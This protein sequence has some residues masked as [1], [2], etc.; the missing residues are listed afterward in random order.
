MKKKLL[1]IFNVLLIAVIA[2]LTV[3][4]LFKDRELGTIL[5]DLDKA[6]KLWLL[7]GAALAVLFVA[8]E[9]VIIRYLLRLFGTRFSLRRCLKYSFV[10]FFFSFITPS[11][12][13][14]QP[15]QLYYMRKD[16]AS[17]GH[18]SIILLLVTITYKAVLVVFGAVFLIFGHS[19]IVSCV[20]DWM[21]LLIVGFVLNIVYIAGLM[22]LL[23]KPAAA[24][25]L[26]SS[27]M[28][29]M[30]RL[31]LIKKNRLRSCIARV[32]NLER[33]YTEAAE[34]I[35]T[36]VGAALK[37]FGM[38]CVQRLM[39]FAVTWVV[40]RSCGLSGTSFMGVIA[41]QTMI[42]ITVEMLPL[43]GAAG[44]TEA[45]FIVMFGGIFG[46][47]FVKTGLLLTRGLTYYLIL[48]IGAAV[49]FGTHIS[50]RRKQSSAPGDKAPAE[51]RFA[52]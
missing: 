38:T 35:K 22:L 33:T 44:I 25:K 31:R 37:V 4:V 11:S 52:A 3:R 30:Y 36:H 26:I 19:F 29:L 46:E 15:A 10:G 28:M 43:P 16:G 27:C 6:D 32:K 34:Y 21:W 20:G 14:G 49:T 23:I 5:G 50:S 13:G 45:C 39:Y 42:C 1:Y 8:G 9:S 18:S 41:V 48:L 12:S 24:C 40:Y 2:V 51:E 47:S 17:L 7:G